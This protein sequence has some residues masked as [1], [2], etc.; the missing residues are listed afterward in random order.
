MKNKQKDKQKEYIG[1]SIINHIE[2]EIGALTLSFFASYQRINKFIELPR[3]LSDDRGFLAR[4]E[5]KEIEGMAISYIIF[6]HE[7]CM[8]GLEKIIE[9]FRYDLKRELN[10]KFHPLDES[11]HLPHMKHL[12]SCWALANIIKHNHSALVKD[13]SNHANYILDVWNAKSGWDLESY[14]L[15]YH[16]MFKI[17]EYIP[18]IYL[19]LCN[20]IEI[21]TG[22]KS[23]FMKDDWLDM[24][25]DFYNYL[26]P[27]TIEVDIPINF[28]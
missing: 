19:S 15:S 20:Y 14:I 21:A 8:L 23:S 24:A 25:K 6:L 27:D 22:A 17:V 7:M 5:K 3:K 9:D 16:D 10:M 1:H 11:L 26:I 12:K 13:S 2:H 4:Y 18:K 28:D